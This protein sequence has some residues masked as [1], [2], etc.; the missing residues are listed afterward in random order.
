MKVGYILEDGKSLWTDRVR[1]L[2]ME[3]NTNRQ[4]SFTKVNLEMAREMDK[5]F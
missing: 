4:N 2:E 5:V 1:N 3:L